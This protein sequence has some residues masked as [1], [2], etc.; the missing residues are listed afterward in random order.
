MFR[1]ENGV[2]LVALVITI[3]VL[4]ILAGVTISMVMGDDGILGNAESAAKDYSNADMKSTVALAA[5]TVNTSALAKKYGGEG[6]Y[7]A[8][9][10]ANLATELGKLLP[11]AT[12]AEDASTITIGNKKW[13][14]TVTE[15]SGTA[16]IGTATVGEY[17]TV[18]E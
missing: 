4:L 15:P 17:T 2:T 16:I 1:K 7:A 6:S 18:A 14:V 11:G 8:F 5:N 10:K 3:I 9:T 13:T 12:I